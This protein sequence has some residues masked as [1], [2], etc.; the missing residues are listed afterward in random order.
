MRMQPDNM[1]IVD[2]RQTPADP[3]LYTIEP[4]FM[5]KLAH[6]H[7]LFDELSTVTSDALD[8]P[9][10]QECADV[11]VEKV[12]RECM[13]LAQEKEL[14]EV[15]LRRVASDGDAMAEGYDDAGAAASS[16]MEE[17]GANTMCEIS[18]LTDNRSDSSYWPRNVS[19]FHDSVPLMRSDFSCARKPKIW[20]SRHR[21]LI[22]LKRGRHES[23]GDELDNFN[24]PPISRWV[25]INA[26]DMELTA[27]LQDE[28]SA[29]R[30]HDLLTAQ[31]DRLQKTNVYHDTFFI[32]HD[33]AFGTINGWSFRGGV[34]LTL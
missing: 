6:A 33:G 18:M 16:S 28:K 5:K 11:L 26:Q 30:Q 32:W 20:R 27:L 19:Y 14:Y 22:S 24:I 17:V 8:H 9:L 13:E 29:Q 2:P 25:S 23:H 15:A 31:L 3:P 34:F 7:R 12:E 21:N 1:D 10:C 4:S